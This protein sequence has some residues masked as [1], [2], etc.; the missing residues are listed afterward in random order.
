[1]DAAGYPLERGG[2]GVVFRPGSLF[3]GQER[4]VWIT[5]S[6]PNR[7]AG[8]HE[9][10]RFSLAYSNAGARSTLRFA[11]T[12]RV[13]SVAR[14]KDFYAKVDVP[15]WSRSVVVDGY[16]KLQ[17]EVARE[18]KAGR[19]DAALQAVQRFR[20]EN[21]VLNAR[22]QSEPVQQKLDSLGKLEGE[23]AAA[24]EGDDQAA[25][26]NEL[27]KTRSADALDQRRAGSKR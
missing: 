9:V 1:V 15:A 16:N 17:E 14:E 6:V 2:K 4:R 11:E 27:S 24:F 18:V 23:V 13:A 8:E 20:D 3:A 22:L 10:G 7:T 12:P 25:R 5:L 19:R 21:G 26:Q